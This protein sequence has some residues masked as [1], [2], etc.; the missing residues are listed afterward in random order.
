MIFFSGRSTLYKILDECPAVVR[1]SVEGLDNF[2]MEGSRG[3]TE[4]EKIIN[5]LEIPSEE[6]KILIMSLQNAKTYLKSGLKV[7]II[8]NEFKI[9]IHM[10]TDMYIQ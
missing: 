1:K 5:K 3:F 2:V 10:Y 7:S 9:Y 8:R 6:S 4:L